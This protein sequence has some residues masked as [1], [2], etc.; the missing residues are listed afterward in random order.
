M[1]IA[2]T[3]DCN[4]KLLEITSIA[5]D[6]WD[7]LPYSSSTGLFSFNMVILLME[8]NFYSTG[9]FFKNTLGK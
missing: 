9:Y 4:F 8:I 2:V 1:D 5:V 7:D 6:V 3:R